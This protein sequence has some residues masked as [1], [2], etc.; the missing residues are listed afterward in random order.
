MTA[1]SSTPK[2]LPTS[3]VVK[4]PKPTR[5]AFNPHRSL[6]K[7]HLIAAQV[8]H[9]KE[10]ETQL[11]EHLRT[12]IDAARIHTEGQASEYIR[13]VTRAIHQSGGRPRQKTGRPT[14]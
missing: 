5:T 14:T 2:E 7:N 6:E 12:G 9:F 10:A 8:E 3:N 4:V 13:K 1:P 11:P